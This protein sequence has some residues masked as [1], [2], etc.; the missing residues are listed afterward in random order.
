MNRVFKYSEPLFDVFLTKEVTCDKTD[1]VIKIILV[2]LYLR[3][4]G[5]VLINKGVYCQIA[6][7]IVFIVLLAFIIINILLIIYDLVKGKQLAKEIAMESKFSYT[8]G[9]FVYKKCVLLPYLKKTIY[10]R[11]II[12]TSEKVADI[13]VGESYV[14]L[15]G[16]FEEKIVNTKGNVIKKRKVQ[17]VKVPIYFENIDK[18]QYLIKR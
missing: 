10:K 16:L 17:K 9:K 3:L 4:F 15:S 11:Y 12:Y 14:T 5:F 18:L 13:E 2:I 1:K 6:F 7:S 8:D